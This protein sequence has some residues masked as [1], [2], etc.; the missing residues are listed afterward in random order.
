MD[1]RKE[2]KKSGAHG[3]AV[4]QY[5]E[6]FETFDVQDMKRSGAYVYL[7]SEGH[8]CIERGLV[9]REEAQD[10][11]DGAA[12]RV[13]TGAPRA[14]KERPLH[15][16]KLCKRL[17]AHRTAAVQ[18]ELAQQPGVALA[19]LMQRMIPIVF[20]DVYG[21]AYIDHAVRIDVHTTRDALVSSADDMGESVAWKELEAERAKWSRMLPRR[22][23]DLLAWLLQQDTDVMSNLFAFCVAATVDGISAADRP[24]AVN[25]VANTLKVD[26]ARYWK[27]TRAAYFEHVAKDR[28]VTVV[29]ES[30]SPQAAGELRGMKKDAAAATA[31]QRMMDSGWLPEVLRNREVPQ[32]ITWDHDDEDGDDEEGEAMQDA[33]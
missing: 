15:G 31:E 21:H 17:T 4:D 19:V 24:H 9:R 23:G 33:A 16:E 18:I 3:F 20:D 26:L 1:S 6:R 12:G 28:I 13:V 25:E 2:R 8:V 22:V 10:E 32:R 5:A 29:G 14:P 7:D 30:V 11:P 27:P